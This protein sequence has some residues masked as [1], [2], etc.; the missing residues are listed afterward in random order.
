M[1]LEQRICCIEKR[2][3]LLSRLVY[4]SLA[5][6]CLAVFSAA[7][8]FDRLKDIQTEKL[9]ILNGDGNIRMRLGK[10]DAGYGVVIYDA[11]G[12]FRATLTDAPDGAGIQLIKDGGKVQLFSYNDGS[13]MS[14]RDAN[15]KPRVGLT[16]TESGP[17]LQLSNE[18]GEPLFK[19]PKDM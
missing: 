1:K 13:G 16:V 18:K 14:I 7:A 8:N 17:T 12:R 5:V 11:A 10:A 3:R 4:A 2:C 15:G 9:E 19:S 6:I